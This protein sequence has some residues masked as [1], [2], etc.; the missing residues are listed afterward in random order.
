[1]LMRAWLSQMP[2]SLLPP[3]LLF[4]DLVGIPFS[5]AGIVAFFFFL[6]FFSFFFEFFSP[7]FLEAT[8]FCCHFPRILVF[9]CFREVRRRERQEEFSVTAIPLSGLHLVG[10]FFMSLV[11]PEWD[12]LRE[13]ILKRKYAP[14]DSL[15]SDSTT[16]SKILTQ[17]FLVQLHYLK[18]ASVCT[19]LSLTAGTC[20]SQISFS[21]SFWWV[22]KKAM[23]TCSLSDLFLF[24]WL[25]ADLGSF[26][27]PE[28]TKIRLILK[29]T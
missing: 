29:T 11:S 3:S 2:Q 18:L 24:V 14:L 1:M 15:P 23:T 7:S 6:F 9:F 10:N 21:S 12:Q 5:S 13:K 26:S 27:F 17:F 28:E 4:V 16:P 19:S 8:T 25:S 22:Q 20:L